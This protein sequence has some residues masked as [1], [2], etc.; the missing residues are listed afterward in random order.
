MSTRTPP[1]RP[2]QSATLALPNA[3]SSLFCPTAKRISLRFNYLRTLCVFTRGVTHSAIPEMKLPIHPY[4]PAR[5]SPLAA[6]LTKTG[7]GGS[8][9]DPET[10]FRFVPQSGCRK[11]GSARGSYFIGEIQPKMLGGGAEP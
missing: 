10:Q 3:L 9:A 2:Q 5:V 7:G 8:Q 1:T 4:P 6:T 11:H